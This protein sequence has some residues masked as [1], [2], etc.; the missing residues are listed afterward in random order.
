MVLTYFGG[1]W[2]GMGLSGCTGCLWTS[3]VSREQM[4]GLSF[5]AEYDSSSCQVLP[6][7]LGVRTGWGRASDLIHLGLDWLGTW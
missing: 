6:A 4:K 7:C 1:A 3:L 2:K 5:S